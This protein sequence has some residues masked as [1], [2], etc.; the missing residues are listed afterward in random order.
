MHSSEPSSDFHEGASQTSQ[1]I[2]QIHHDHP[3]TI[4]STEV[5]INKNGEKII[6]VVKKRRVSAAATAAKKNMPEKSHLGIVI[7]VVLLLVLGCGIYF[8]WRVTEM[9]STAYK[10]CK[11]SELKDLWNASELSVGYA[12]VDSFK[13]AISEINAE[14]PEENPIAKVRLIGLSAPLSLR[15]YFSSMPSGNMLEIKRAE[16]TLRNSVKTMSTPRL[17]NTPI[18]YF[19]RIACNDF[20]IKF[21]D[22]Q[23]APFSLKA[24]VYI[25]SPNNRQGTHSMALKSGILKLRAWPSIQITGGQILSSYSGLEEI[26]V[27][28]ILDTAET[29]LVQNEQ[30]EILME[31]S[32]MEGSPITGEFTIVSSNADLSYFTQNKF[33][34]IMSAK[35]RSDS[36]W[37]RDKNNRLSM[38]L[39]SPETLLPPS[40]S[41]KI[42]LQDIR[43]ENRNLT[44]LA[45]LMKHVESNRRDKYAPPIFQ[46]GRATLVQRNGATRLTIQKDDMADP[47]VLTVQGYLSVDQNDKLSGALNYGIP[48]RLAQAEYSGDA[49]PIF[50]EEHRLA[51]LKTS[52]SGKADSPTDNAESIDKKAEGKRKSMTQPRALNLPTHPTR[53]TR[54][55]AAIPS[56]ERTSP[57]QFQ[58]PATPQQQQDAENIFMRTLQQGF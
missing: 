41:G 34:R 20:R 45:L 18:W 25:Y 9:S 7:A 32:V 40:F 4:K 29:S 58:L 56:T 30:A 47:A 49:D 55:E 37:E 16:I 12:S 36:K 1:I 2:E 42:L 28:G 57:S 26:S 38:K 33:H 21:E 15:S 11:Q 54:T 22:E 43:F 24:S 6:R 5:V 44:G 13:L 52:L 35:T 51:W 23:K 14:F 3:S 17:T 31:G 27:K 50:I 19:D 39:P 46:T 53:G 8:T 10:E 48:L